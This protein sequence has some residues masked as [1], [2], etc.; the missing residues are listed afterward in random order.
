MK[1]LF[2]L[3]AMTMF[4]AA[5][6]QAQEP[7]QVTLKLKNGATVSGKVIN[8]GDDSMKI[9]T[10]EGDVFIYR[11]NEISRIEGRDTADSGETQMQKRSING[12]GG[13]KGYRSFLDVGYSYG[14]DDDGGS[15][16][17]SLTY[18]GGYNFSSYLYV[19]LGFGA[20]ITDLIDGD[21]EMGL[22]IFA[23][24]RSAF[25]KKS[26]TSPFVSVNVG[27]SVALSQSEEI[28]S[29]GWDYG[30]GWPSVYDY[31]GFYLEP[32]IGIEVRSKKPEKKSA[33]QVGVIFTML[34]DPNTYMGVGLKLGCSF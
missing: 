23:H 9:Q 21:T 10:P 6:T 4:I 16:R 15:D 17:I 20:S 1:K 7:E 14:I 8:E 26:R 29:Y 30:Y 34:S 27:Y 32:C 11:I 13:A 28:I 33:F 3:V 31:S 24:I 22:P 2:L 18:I 19:G 12:Y 5:A 25:L